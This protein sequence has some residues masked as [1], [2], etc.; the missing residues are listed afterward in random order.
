M[1]LFGRP[2]S[3]SDGP[4][5]FTLPPSAR[6]LDALAVQLWAV[7]GGD[8]LAL[9]DIQVF[10]P[11][12][13][14]AR[15]LTE[16]L[17]LRSPSG[18]ALIAPSIRPLGDL[19]ADEKPFEPAGPALSAPPAVSEARR[20]FELA[21]LVEAKMLAEGRARDP[22]AALAAARELARVIDELET[23]EIADLS[24]LDA[25]IRA[26]LPEHLQRAASFLDIVT[27]HWPARLAE[28][29]AA[30]EAARRAGLLRMLAAQWEANPPPGPVIAAGSTGTAPATAALLR[31]IARLPQGAVILP[32]LDRDLDDGAWSHIDD[33]HPQAQ[34]K[35]LLR[36]LGVARADVADLPGAA[37][38]PAARPR[39]R[40]IA[41]ALLPAEASGGMLEGV[42][43]IAAAQGM[44][45]GE[46]AKTALDGLTLIEARSEEEEAL[47]CALAV[48]NALEG[49]GTVML[50]TPDTALAARVSARLSRWDIEA[51]SSAGRP[52]AETPPASF[53]WLLLELAREPDS[54]L[55]LCAL[56]K[57]PLCALGRTRPRLRTEAA[58]IE[59]RSLRGPR[60]TD[61]RA[62]VT[63]DKY[64]DETRRARLLALIDDTRAALAPLLALAGARPAPERARALAESAEAFARTPDQEGAARVWAGEG[65][66]GAADLLRE[67]MAEGGALPPLDAHDFA[68]LFAEA[69]QG[70]AVR[71]RAGEH[72]RLRIL[73]PLEA[74]LQS[75][76]LVILAGLNEGVW[77]RVHA[78]EPFLSREMRRGVGLDA[79]ERRIGQAAHDFAQGAG[80]PRLILSR[81]RRRDG[82]PAVASRFLWRLK[83]LAAGALDLPVDA[84]IPE[85]PALALARALDHVPAAEARPAPPPAPRP[86]LAARPRRASATSLR[87]WVRDPYSVY[88]KDVL[89]LEAL[90]PVDAPPGAAER[91]TAIH[92]AL[93]SCFDALAKDG[94]QEALAELTAH[95]ER[96]L[97][98]CGLAPEQLA[99]ALPRFRRA[100]RWLVT[101]EQKRRAAGWV[102]IAR[103]IKRKWVIEMPGGPFTII[104]KADRLDLRGVESAIIDYKTGS[105]PSPNEVKAGF[106]LQMP[107]QAAMARL[108][109][110]DPLLAA[111][112]ASLLYLKLG[113]GVTPGEQA[114]LTDKDWDGDRYA[115]LAVRVVTQ[116]VAFF[117]DPANPYLSQPRAKYVNDYGD[118]DHLARRGEWAQAGGGEE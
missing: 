19:D 67:L 58:E 35:R 46:F 27:T 101:E 74:R 38:G 115:D 53:L 98:A 118:Y 99:F 113:G 82:A 64:P 50:V 90:D 81:A 87:L 23:A 54:T 15:A 2:A 93:E 1:S 94:A 16:A 59:R 5:V 33:Q 11:T 57:H 69:M 102:P 85:D 49:E 114:E 14:A 31:V 18:P 39:R 30:D 65:G 112:P 73:G 92:D 10:L 111:A 32:G 55:A 80:A 28:L 79:P 36:D 63:G 77:P 60:P 7:A 45:P 56:W 72:P 68:R 4:R 71:P 116:L 97:S 105:A 41:Q 17:A 110:F 89:R 61:L 70:R 103:E 8:P 76:D 6:F 43:A 109:L 66:E 13:R 75:A 88:A 20:L 96:A 48:R 34:L 51:Q 86:P 95:G 12:R 84:A 106:D 26:R 42:R 62:A 3:P 9:A 100:A 22:A 52:L 117:D 83:T 44:A 37:E 29:G 21:R 108:G 24:G 107:V 47:A 91:G 104:A 40:L 78:G 25:D